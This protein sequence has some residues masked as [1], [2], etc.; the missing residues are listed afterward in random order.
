MKN[1]CRAAT[2][3]FL[4]FVLSTGLALAG[5]DSTREPVSSEDG[6]TLSEAPAESVQADVEPVEVRVASLKG[7]TTIGLASFIHEVRQGSAEVVNSYDFTI[8]GSADEILPGLIAGK[9]DIALV[10]ANVASVLYNRTEGAI[11]VA[12]INTLG[13]LYVVTA[14][15]SIDSLASLAGHTVL[16][17]GKGTTPEYVMDALLSAQG[18]GDVVL[19]YKSEATELAAAISADPTAIAV[20]PQP[21]AAAVTSKNPS[22]EI[23]VSLS[24]EWDASFGGGSRLVTGTTVVRAEFASAHPAAVAEFLAQQQISVDHANAAPDEVGIV[25]AELGII[26]DAKIAAYAIPYCS[27]IDISGTE[28]REALDGYL[29]VLFARDAASVGGILPGEGFY[30]PGT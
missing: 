15:T 7:P 10:P 21:Y 22:L 5:C 26:D 14:D 29:A 30:Y 3:V 25:V 12:N 17:T 19:E 8:A 27:L 20:L 18:V 23:R 1:R 6:V 4:A 2:L 28:M 13:V 11:Q 16:M 24:D 9:L